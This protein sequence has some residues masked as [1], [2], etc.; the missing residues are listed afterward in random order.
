VD[1]VDEFTGQKIENAHGMVSV[2]RWLG[3]GASG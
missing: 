1:D 3:R 2:V